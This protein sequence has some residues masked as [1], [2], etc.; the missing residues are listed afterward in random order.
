MI[1]IIDDSKK[2]SHTKLSRYRNLQELMPRIAILGIGGAGTNS[3]SALYRQIGKKIDGVKFFACN[4]DVQSL[5][6]A[7]RSE[8]GEEYADNFEIIVLGENVTRGKGAGGDPEVGRAAAQDTLEEIKAHIGKDFDMAIIT[9][10]MGG[11]TGTFAAS[12]IGKALKAS[13][14]LTIGVVTKP[15]SCE[16]SERMKTAMKGIK[17]LKESIDTLIVTSNN[18]LNALA[19]GVLSYKKTL[20]IDEFFLCE[21]VNNIVSLIRE[22]GRINLDFADLSFVTRNKHSIGMV[23]YGYAEGEGCGQR[24]IKEAMELLY[25]DSD[26][27]EANNLGINWSNVENALIQISLG[28]DMSTTD[29]D[30]ACSYLLS[31]VAPNAK[32]K[33]GM[34]IKEGMVGIKVFAIGTTGNKATKTIKYEE[35]PY[36][37]MHT[38]KSDFNEDHAI[39][40]SKPSKRIGEDDHSFLR[41][42]KKSKS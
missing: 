8:D 39:F 16:G 19:G 1:K 32:I 13:G 38:G 14:I 4:T 22:T 30:E 7:F 10:G 25:L 26:E 40:Q 18:K 9:T 17:E 35:S 27:D 33:T 24:A 23:G 6:S 41:F 21:I 36:R 15:F 2:I 42:F 37:S 3:V 31:S 5:M 34:I 29:V 28:E 11:G 20:E 12:E